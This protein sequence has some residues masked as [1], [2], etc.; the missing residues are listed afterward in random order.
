M[1]KWLILCGNKENWNVAIERK[2][3][4]VKPNLSKLWNRLSEGDIIFFYVTRPIRRIIGVGRVVDKLDPKFH[5]PKPL[6]SDEIREGR[7]IYPYRFEFQTLHVCRGD[8]SLEGISINGLKISVQKAMSS[9]LHAINDLHQRVKTKWDFDIPLPEVSI[10]P[11][12]GKKRRMRIKPLRD[13][14]GEP[15]NFRGFVYAPLNEAGVILLFSKVMED[16]GIIYE[17]SPPMFPDMVA[18][19][20][21]KGGFEKVYIEFEYRSSNFLDHGHDVNQCDI[22]VCWEHN[23]EDCPLEVIELKDFI[24]KYRYHR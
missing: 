18:R 9:I 22:I 1:V 2:V 5:P 11:V 17:S 4:G 3:W 13:V 15:I 10:P 21:V 14:V 12:P 6:W 8:L 7:V 23:W 16:L 19:R 20:K 24:R